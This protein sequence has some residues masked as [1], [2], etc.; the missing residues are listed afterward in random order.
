M[1]QIPLDNL[2]LDRLRRWPLGA[3]MLA[4]QAVVL[5]T[6]AAHVH[7]PRDFLLLL[8][9]IAVMSG[10][11][12][13][14]HRRRYMLLGGTPLARIG[15][16][17]QGYVQV[18]GVAQALDDGTLVCP[19]VD[20]RCV[21]YQ[22]V[23]EQRQ[24]SGTQNGGEYRYV[25]TLQSAHGFLLA[26]DT[27]RCLIDPDG[28]EIRSTDTMVEHKDNWR[29]TAR[30]ICE[31]EPIYAIGEFVS[32]RDQPVDMKLAVSQKLADWKRDRAEL[33][34]RFD[35]DRNGQIDENEWTA[36]RKAAEREVSDETAE[37]QMQAPA[38][39]MRASRDGR[40]FLVATEDPSEGVSRNRRWGW[41]HLALL[42]ATLFGTLYLAHHPQW[43]PGHH[44]AAVDTVSGNAGNSNP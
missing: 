44:P 39:V 38:H 29:Y 23:V 14:H 43:I 20:M 33:L 2:W 32:V 18:A 5:T 30:M 12:W 21:W 8:C 6:G 7:R 3:V 13:V 42:L 40:P 36:A 19:G 11:A 35:T 16:A 17:P 15:S 25:D 24:W 31:G 22:V 1:L 27:G 28:A 9:L 34:R 10:W 26:D 4:A 41:L 37:A